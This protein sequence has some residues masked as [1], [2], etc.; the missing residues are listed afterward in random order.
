MSA[1][2]DYLLIKE[3]TRLG[4]RNQPTAGGMNR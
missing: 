1:L 3:I 4:N 2:L